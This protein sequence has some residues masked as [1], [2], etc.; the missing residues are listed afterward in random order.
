M[1]R[2]R[3]A[4]LQN[5]QIALR[6]HRH[7]PDQFLQV[8]NMGDLDEAQI[9]RFLAATRDVLDEVRRARLLASPAPSQRAG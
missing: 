4:A 5:L 8:A 3:A 6:L 7:L 9:E 2:T 1:V